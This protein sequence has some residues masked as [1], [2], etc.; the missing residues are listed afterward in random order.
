MN[1]LLPV[2]AHMMHPSGSSCLLRGSASTRRVG[3][4]ASTC[5]RHVRVPSPSALGDVGP[6][7]V[8]ESSIHGDTE[9]PGLQGV[10][11]SW[12]MCHI[13]AYAD[14]IPN[15]GSGVAVSGGTS[16]CELA[17]AR[18]AS[19]ATEQLMANLPDNRPRPHSIKGS[20]TPELSLEEPS[21]IK[22][23]WPGQPPLV[24][25][26]GALQGGLKAATG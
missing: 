25:R 11:G 26:R 9:A 6:V 18:S 24:P 10:A 20:N 7:R 3:C 16:P 14:G 2:P 19:P 21:R 17:P 5:G 4:T 12:G 22:S 8:T 15:W 13:A 23:V 1:A